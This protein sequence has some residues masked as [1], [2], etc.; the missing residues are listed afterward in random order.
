MFNKIIRLKWSRRIGNRLCKSTTVVLPTHSID[1][2]LAFIRLLCYKAYIILLHFCIVPIQPLRCNIAINVS[3]QAVGSI[4]GCIWNNT[5]YQQCRSLRL[6]TVTWTLNAVTS[7]CTY[8]LIPVVYG[9][10]CEW[11][12]INQNSLAIPQWRYR[13]KLCTFYANF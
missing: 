9:V 4:P 6:I 13:A 2:M 12:L 5:L 7:F 10:H 8:S 11:I 1:S 3:Y